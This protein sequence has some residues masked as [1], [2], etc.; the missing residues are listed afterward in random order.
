V[1]KRRVSQQAVK[2]SLLKRR[3]RMATSPGRFKQGLPK[4]TGEYEQLANGVWRKK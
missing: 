2:E 3:K 1:T 4:N